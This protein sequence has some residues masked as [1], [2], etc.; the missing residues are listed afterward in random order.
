MELIKTES[1][2]ISPLGKELIES[3]RKAW[4]KKEVTREVVSV[5]DAGNPVFIEKVFTVDSSIKRLNKHLPASVFYKFAE[6]VKPEEKELIN[7]LIEAGTFE[8]EKAL[9]AF[10]TSPVVVL[11]RKIKPTTFDEAHKLKSASIIT[12]MKY[13][14]EEK[15]AKLLG[16]LL[17]D[18]AK[19]FGKRNDLEQ[20]DIKELALDIV[21]SSEF[22]GFTVADLKMILN[23]SIKQTKKQFNLD[24]QTIVAILNTAKEDK[25]VYFSNKSME[26]HRHLTGNEKSGEREAVKPKKI[27]T[28]AFAKEIAR[29][30]IDK[31]KLK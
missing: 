23:N 19:K 17:I 26:E 27:D 21:N 3:L 22:R 18:F 15:A 11:D 2:Q 31:S 1:T 9:Q 29:K 6:L 8:V 20:N 10:E 7:K 24:Y 13:K 5:D 12:L 30:P 28:A 4:G 14:G 25:M 16:V